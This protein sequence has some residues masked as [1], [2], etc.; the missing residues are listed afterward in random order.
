MAS[1]EQRDPQNGTAVEELVPILMKKFPLSLLP[2]LLSSF[3]FPCGV[4][5][6]NQGK[7]TR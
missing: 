2:H 3:M 4:F 7:D 5:Q 1:P 6:R